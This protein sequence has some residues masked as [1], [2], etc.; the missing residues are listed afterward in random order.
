MNVMYTF[1]RKI[2]FVSIGFPEASMINNEFVRA[3]GAKLEIETVPANVI[4][5]LQ[6]RSVDACIVSTKASKSILSLIKNIKQNNQ[7]SQLPLIIISH[8]TDWDFIQG[9][10]DT[11]ANFVIVEPVTMDKANECL[12]I[13]ESMLRSFDRFKL[14]KDRVFR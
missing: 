12:W 8:E 5:R 4:A 13:I 9:L 3:G 11:G 1:E 6:D 7:A 2:L 10:Y 14:G